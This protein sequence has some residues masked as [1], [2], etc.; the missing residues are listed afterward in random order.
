VPTIIPITNASENPSNTGPAI[1]LGDDFDD[2]DDTPAEMK[3][4]CEWLKNAIEI[5]PMRSYWRIIALPCVLNR[6]KPASARARA[7]TAVA[8][9]R[10]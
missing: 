4:T 3:T 10:I 6:R 8:F 1:F 2:F 5:A 7:P 9:Y